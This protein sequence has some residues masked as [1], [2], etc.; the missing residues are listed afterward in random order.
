M[1]WSTKSRHERGY[2]RAWDKLRQ[3]IL[4]R[5]KFICQMCRVKGRATPA[6]QVDHIK[7]RAKGGTDY[8]DNL[9][10]LCEE[11]HKAKTAVDMGHRV[12][13]TIGVDGWPA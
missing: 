4:A 2:G 8:A 9:Q 5:D 11:C 13:I 7:P 10:A 3:V 12:K 6:N 1:A